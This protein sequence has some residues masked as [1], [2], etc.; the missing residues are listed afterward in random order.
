MCDV[1]LYAV[2]WSISYLLFEH[3]LFNLTYTRHERLILRVSFT[4]L[5]RP[6]LKP[7]QPQTYRNPTQRRYKKKNRYYTLGAPRIKTV[8]S[9]LQ[10]ERARQL[11]GSGHTD[12]T[13]LPTAM[14]WGSKYSVP[15]ITFSIEKA[16]AEPE[17]HGIVGLSKGGSLQRTWL[18]RDGVD[19]KPF[20]NIPLLQSVFP[21]AVVW[22]WV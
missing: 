3:N 9:R 4:G 20:W 11:R 2:L 15:R 16:L 7:T 10:A 22:A 14:Q 19:K 17:T 21:K 13:I 18:S 1:V 5:L 6:L 12:M 8:T